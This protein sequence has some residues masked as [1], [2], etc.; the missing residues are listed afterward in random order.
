MVMQ[1]GCPAR[2]AHQ[3][4]GLTFPD[5]FTD[6]HEIFRV[7]GITGCITIAMVMQL[8]TRSL[9]GGLVRALAYELDRVDAMAAMQHLEVQ[10]WPGCPARVAH[11][12]HSLA[13][14][15][16]FT[17]RHEIFRVVGITSCITIAMVDLDQ[18]TEA[19][20]RR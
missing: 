15:D 16:F 6:R 11:Q 19:V 12:G 17:D 3:G 4:H 13:F 14:P 8:K 20:A 7:V 10:I 1:P 9:D 5:L 18:L 2:V